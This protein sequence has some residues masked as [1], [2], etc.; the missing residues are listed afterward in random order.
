MP[1]GMRKVVTPAEKQQVN[2]NLGKSELLHSP[3]LAVQKVLWR[4]AQ[5]LKKD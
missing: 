1:V 5:V 3:G 4:W 2:T